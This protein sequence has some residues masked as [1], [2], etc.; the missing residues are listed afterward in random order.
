MK[1]RHYIWYFLFVMVS[2]ICF[3]QTNFSLAK[4]LKQ[5]KIAFK[6]VSNLI[7]IPVEINGVEL[8]FLLDTGVS[9]PILFNFSNV[10]DTLQIKNT[11]KFKLRGLGGDGVIDAYRSRGNMFKI[12]NAINKEQDLFAILDI[13]LD[14][15]PRLGIP[16]HGIIGYDLF[17]D[18][19]IDINYSKKYIRLIPHDNFKEKKY[20]KYRNIPLSFYKKKPYLE[21]SVNK[22]N[23][24]KLLIDTGGSD[25]L[26]LFIDD[27][28]GILEPQHY[29]ND[30]LGKGLS[31]SVYGRRSRIEQFGL[32]G[33]QLKNVNTAYPDSS[34]IAL[35]RQYEER[36]GSVSGDILK[37]FN[38]VFNYRDKTLL[39][40]KNS[41][42]K[43]PFYYN[44]S[45][46]ILEHNGIRFVKEVNKEIII[47]P[48]ASKHVVVAESGV[49][50]VFNAS[51]NY[52]VAPSFKI[53]EL[54]ENSPA[55][56]AGLQIGDIILS[57][58][59]QSAHRFSLQDITQKFYGEDNTLI[60]LQ[61]DRR[62]VPMS[63]KFRLKD[64]LKNP[65]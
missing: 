41:N 63:F 2:S 25:A 57:I 33:Y 51:Y 42:F 23:D 11:E 60:R 20:R 22:I 5:D 29:F 14:F 26:W 45:G 4:G 19:I 36:S 43:L 18:F 21:A 49:T 62:G 64:V 13:T 32:D 27:S 40:K 24:V 55:Y 39:I 53:V 37:R 48:F 31:G 1:A 6:L 3:S 54:R 17:R 10:A 9:K 50:N 15:A 8:S 47:R 28:K 59:R 30:F 35:A 52:I 16:I 65:H 34:S 38:L 56:L 61:I 46:I 7:V 12:G 58:G 44:K